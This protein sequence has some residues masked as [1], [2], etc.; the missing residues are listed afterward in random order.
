MIPLKKTCDEFTKS[1]EKINKLMYMDDIKIFG[2]N[3]KE[4]EIFIQIISINSQDIRM[5]LKDVPLWEHRTRAMH[6]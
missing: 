2:K 5:E 4:L 6:S 1:L 3:L